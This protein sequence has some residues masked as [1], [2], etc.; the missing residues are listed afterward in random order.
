MKC[1]TSAGM[2]SGRRRWRSGQPLLDSVQEYAYHTYIR[3]IWDPRKAKANLAKHGIR[4]SDAE[5]V[6]FD[7]N[8][9]T[10]DDPAA[11]REQRF[12]SIGLDHLARILVVAFAYRARSCA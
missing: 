12:V 7:P 4:F 1:F 8:A 10:S 6:L 11:R 2:S 5:G 3:I 9:L